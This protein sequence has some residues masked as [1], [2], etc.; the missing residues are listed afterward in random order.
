MAHYDQI[1]AMLSIL[2]VYSVNKNCVNRTTS[3]DFLL[4]LNPVGRIQGDFSSSPTL[5]HSMIASMLRAVRKLEP[6]RQQV[7]FAKSIGCHHHHR[8][9]GKKERNT[10]R[11]ECSKGLTAVHRG[12]RPDPRLSSRSSTR[13]IAFS[14]YRNSLFSNSNL[15]QGVFV[16]V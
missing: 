9:A 13:F 7:A 10:T 4:I 15:V 14:S 8:R 12:G 5:D 11:I 6:T 3:H 2:S 16:L 1:Y